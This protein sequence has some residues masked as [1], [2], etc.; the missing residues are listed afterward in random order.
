MRL[1]ASIGLCPQMCDAGIENPKKNVWLN[2]PRD[3][4]IARFDLNDLWVSR[5]KNFHGFKSD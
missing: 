2:K 4:D 3:I 5:E 1:R